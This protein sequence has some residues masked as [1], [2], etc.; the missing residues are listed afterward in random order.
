MCM[1]SIV[2]AVTTAVGGGAMVV[3][4]DELYCYFYS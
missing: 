4:T 3:A 2:V 1:L